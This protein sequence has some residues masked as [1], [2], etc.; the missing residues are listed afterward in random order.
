MKLFQELGIGLGPLEVAQTPLAQR[1][2]DRSQRAAFVRQFVSKARWLLLVRLS[3]NK[4]DRF[5]S[6]QAVC[7]NVGRNSF[8]RFEKLAVTRL[9]QKEIPNDQ[10]RP[11]IAEDI[12]GTANGAVRSWRKICSSH[13]M[14]MKIALAVCK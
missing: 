5:E 9:A 2:E 11:T 7:E 13:L 4:T 8:R 3:G 6:L 12:K 10:Q 14:T 1:A